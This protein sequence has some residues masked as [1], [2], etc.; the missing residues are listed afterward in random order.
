[1]LEDV[2][3]LDEIAILGQWTAIFA[4]PNTGKTLITLFLLRKQINEGLIDGQKVFY[5]NA[6]DHYKGVTEKLEIAED[7]GMHVLVPGHEGFS[8]TD[9]FTLMNDFVEQDD[10]K[11]VVIILD[12]LKKFTDPMD[13]RVARGFGIKAR[14][15]VTAGGTLIVLAHNNKHKGDDGRGIYAGTSD[16]VDDADC[17]FG[18]DKVAESD[19][20]LGKKITV[21]FT[22]TKSRGNVASTVG[23]TYL[24]KDHSYAD[25]LDSVVKLDETKLKLSK[26]EIEL[27]ESLE[28]DKHIISEVRQAIIDGFDK[29]NILIK[30]V[31]IR[32]CESS[33]K[34]RA[35]IEERAGNDFASGDRWS[36]ALG[37]KNAQ[38]FSVLPIPLKT[39]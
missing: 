3:V 2:F 22:N 1:M 34:V 29:K 8:S 18:I 5:I 9:I 36:F 13:K 28:R 12:T 10:A 33:R 26:Q 37:E 19:E 32:T 38:I 21:E 14:E 27:K 23:F 39:K 35:V 31:M 7:I 17:A 30:E 11:N 20:F 6:D 15:F 25:L 4:S 24:K 16:I